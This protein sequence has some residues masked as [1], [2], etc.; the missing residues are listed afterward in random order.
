MCLILLAHRTHPRYRL[1]LAANRDEFYQRPARPMAWWKDEP[2]ILAGRDLEA[3]GTWLGVS[4]RGRLAALTNIREP[5]HHLGEA[6]SRGGLVTAFVSG[7]LSPKAFLE[8]L[9]DHGCTYNGYNLICADPAHLFCGSNRQEVPE[10][11][12]P[13]IHGLS[14]RHLNTPW[15]KL[16]RGKSLLAALLKREDPVSAEAL[17]E[18]LTDRSRPADE[19]LPDTGVGIERERM[20]SPMFIT[21]ETYG[22]RCSTAILWEREGAVEVVERSWEPVGGGKVCENG[23]IRHRLQVPTG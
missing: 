11:I 9:A 22:T 4:R 3:G 16:E 2:D 1:V 20:L 8:K 15:P 21:S 6:P 18:M 17:L 19:L 7:T 5:Q 23:T 10:E 12:P 13:G 14:N